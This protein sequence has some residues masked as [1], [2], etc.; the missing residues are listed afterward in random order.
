MSKRSYSIEKID[1][2]YVVSRQCIHNIEYG[3]THEPFTMFCPDIELAMGLLLVAEEEYRQG[4]KS[5]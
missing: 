4:E 5:K 3:E 2:G 1:N